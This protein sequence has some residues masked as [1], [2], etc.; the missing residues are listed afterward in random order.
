MRNANTSSLVGEVP[1]V[2]AYP[3]LWIA[4][5]DDYERAVSLLA[6][7]R[8]G[9]SPGGTPD[10]TCPACRE[11]VPGNFASCWNCETLRPDGAQ[12]P[13]PETPAPLPPPAS[14]R[15]PLTV[16][17]VILAALVFA[18]K[19]VAPAQVFSFLAPDAFA[20]YGGRW[21][22]LL[23]SVFVHADFMH[24]AFNL[25][26]LWVFGSVLEANLK[27]GLWLLLFLSTAVFSSATQLAFGDGSTGIGLSGA[28]YGL[29]GFLWLAGP[30]FPAFAAVLTPNR[31][32]LLLGW[33]VI[34]FGLTYLKVY[35]V[36]N[37]AHVGGLVAGS[38][39]GWAFCRSR[40][41]A[42]RAGIAFLVLAFASVLYAPWSLA[43]QVATASA[44][45]KKG[46]MDR[47]LLWLEP[48]AQADGYLAG[49]AAY[50]LAHV[51]ETQGNYSAAAKAYET[52]V[53]KSEKSAELLNAYA[54]LLATAPAANVRDGKKAL[55]LARKAADLTGWKEPVILDTVAAACA[56]TGDFDSAVKWQTAAVE[57]GLNDEEVHRHLKLY[58]QRKPVRDP[59]EAAPRTP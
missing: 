17:C 12:I 21:D 8:S 18:W 53:Q 59:A 57:S 3:E 38:L 44:L 29:F 39:L 11:T 33:L 34:C 43:F 25:Y 35:P 27:R 37:A 16:T 23:G 47:A 24:L 15:A 32:M 51:R 55:E 52:A 4:N 40:K 45:L 22:A 42:L 54:W 48:A 50:C 2:A 1:F 7:Y 56:E 6:E 36:A 9:P 49:W 14:S 41:D 46:E 26:W 19:L 28:I 10:W 13:P 5:D 58:Q 20:I 31:K 30:R